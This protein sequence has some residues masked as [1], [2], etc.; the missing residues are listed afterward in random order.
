ML[1]KVLVCCLFLLL[2]DNVFAQKND[3]LLKT[4]SNN[5][6][7]VKT[8]FEKVKGFILR[9]TFDVLSKNCRPTYFD[10]QS[11][12]QFLNGDKEKPAFATM[13]GE[14]AKSVFLCKIIT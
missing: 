5:I 2:F 11:I 3:T 8:R 12:E 1:R 9:E 13:E 10:S 6:L 4:I 7:S 14:K